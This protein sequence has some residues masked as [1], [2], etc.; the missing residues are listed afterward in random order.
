[1]P[2]PFPRALPRPFP[3]RIFIWTRDR[4][5]ARGWPARARDNI[6]A[7]RLSK[8]LEEC[9]RARPRPRN[10]RSCCASSASAP[11]IWPRT[12]FPLPGADGFRPGWEEIGGDLAERHDAGGIRRPAAGDAIRPLH[13]RAGDPQPLARRP[14]S[15]LRPAGAS[16]SRAWARACSSRCCRRPCATATRLTGVEYDPITAR[17][18]AP[19]PSARPAC[20]ARITPAAPSAGASISRSATRPSRT[21]SSA[22]TRRP[23]PSVCACTTT[24]SPARSAGCGPAASPLFVTST[25]TMDKASDDR[26]RAHRQHGGPDRRRAPARGHHAR[27]RRHRGRYRRSGVSTPGRG[28]GAELARTGW[29]SARLDLEDSETAGRGSGD[30]DLPA[31]DLPDE[32]GPRPGVTSGR[33]SSRSTSISPTHPEM[34]LG[35]HGQRRGIYG[36][37][38]SYTCRPVA[39]RPVDRD[40]ARHGPGRLPA[41][42]FAGRPF[43]HATMTP[44]T[45][46]ATVRPGTAADGATIKEGSFLIGQGGRLSQIVG[47]DRRPGRDQGRPQ[48]G[49]DQH[50]RP[51]RSSVAC[52]RSVTPSATC[53]AP[54]RAGRPWAQAQVRLR[55]AYSGFIRYHGPINHTVVTTLTDAETGEEREVHRRPNLAH[56][57]DD[58]DCWLVASIEDYDLESGLGPHGTDLPRAGHRPADHP[59]HHLRGRRAR[60]HPERGRPCR[61]RPSRRA[62]WNATPDAA[63]QQLGTAV[64]RNPMTAGV[65]DG[66][67]LPLRRGAHQAGRRRSGRHP[68]P[69]IRAERRWLCGN[70]SRRTCHPPESPPAS[71]RRGFRPT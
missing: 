59:A 15:R 70:A 3:G 65:G 60:R 57:A 68:R 10:R 4:A 50:A 8:E 27:D 66:R 7:I 16:S 11:R 9:R 64:F 21:A 34:V 1:M 33:A 51:P 28:T 41:A 54:R 32:R 71:A 24:S 20:A 55:C 52:C 58:P 61:P 2:F 30:E 38:F 45:S 46:S 17:I 56:F 47:G 69:A 67:R 36:P 39:D 5:L 37:G 6:A 18:A 40:S 29:T 44:T 26:P 53:C 31:D 22:P 42:I 19:D 48:R 63:L 23:P 12:A 49:G 13:P 43:R 14:A 62:F 35:T 25:G